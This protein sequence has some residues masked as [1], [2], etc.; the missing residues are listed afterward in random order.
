MKT[1]SYLKTVCVALLAPIIAL[2]AQDVEDDEESIFTLS[3]F[4][5]QEDEAIGY[6]ALSTLA[7]TRIKTD[8][9]DVG[10]AI[11]VYTEE[12]MED[13]GATDGETLLSYGLNTETI[14]EQG[15]FAGFGGDTRVLLKQPQIAGQRVRGITLPGTQGS[16][17]LTRDFFLTDMPFDSYNTTAVTVNRGPNSLLFGTGKAG[18]IINNATIQASVAESFGEIQI[19]I[20]ENSSHREQIDYNKVLVQDRLAIRVAAL[21]EDQQFHQRPSFQTDER[22]F[23]TLT[24]VLSKNESSDFFGPTILR[25]NIETADLDGTPVKVLPPPDDISDWWN[26]S[27]HAPRVAY[28]EETW[29]GNVPDFVDGSSD[30]QGTFIPQYTTGS[31]HRMPLR[32]DGAFGDEPPGAMIGAYSGGSVLYYADINDPNPTAG[33]SMPGLHGFSG[34][35]FWDQSE[36]CAD[37]GR[38]WDLQSHSIFTDGNQGIGRRG[39]WTRPTLNNR[40]VLDNTKIN[41]GGNLNRSISEFDA[42]NITLEQQLFDGKGGIEFAYD[43]QSY[44]SHS[45]TPYGDWF[46]IGVDVNENL[47]NDQ[48]NP[49][50]G[51]AFKVAEIEQRKNRWDRE[52]NR[53]TAFYEIDLTEQEGILGWLGRHVL[54]G[55]WNEQQIDFLDLDARNRWDEASSNNDYAGRSFRDI[56]GGGLRA[57]SGR[58]GVFMKIYLSD[59][60][61]GVSRFEDVRLNEYPRARIPGEGT[62]WL[63][64]WQDRRGADPNFPDVQQGPLPNPATIADPANYQ[65][66]QGLGDPLY[67]NNFK[68]TDITVQVGAVNRQVIESE[69]LAWQGKWWNDHIVTLLGWRTDTSVSQS[70]LGGGVDAEGF[71]LPEQYQLGPKNPKLEGNTTTVGV[72]AHLPDEWTGDQFGMSFHYNESDSFEPK[73]TSFNARV[74]AL[75]SP[76]AVTEDYGLTFEFLN[77]ALSLRLSKYEMTVFATAGIGSSEIERLTGVLSGGLGVQEWADAWIDGLDFDETYAQSARFGNVGNFS[78]YQDVLNALDSFIPEP[79]RSTVNPHFGPGQ[80][81]SPDAFLLVDRIPNFAT[82]SDVVS[83]GTE[84]E[85][86]GNITSNW[87]V[88]LN[89]GEQ[90]TSQSNSQ[91]AL[92]AVALE[93]QQNLR[94]LNLH[95]LQ[96]NPL[97]DVDETIGDVFEGIV[98]TPILNARARDGTVSQEQR[99]KRINLITAYDWTEGPLAGFGAGGAYRWQDEIAAGYPKIVS[100]ETGAIIDDVTQP[101]FGPS[102]YN[103]DL[104]FS[105][106]GKFPF[107]LPFFDHEKMDWK[108]QLNT[109]NAFGDDDYIPVRYNPDGYI[110]VVRNP[111]PRSFWLTNTFSF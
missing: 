90:E 20:G 66:G 30:A 69:A 78:S 40:Q 81:P 80:P 28:M 46:G 67:Y 4:T 47:P 6:Q 34:I 72:V 108:I 44:F 21:N 36:C 101:I 48:P 76:N 37:R 11:S 5:I 17:S 29:T 54:T 18:G 110:A 106:A 51:R 10:A 22:W 74:E 102:T 1:T 43:E 31:F 24:A 16:A 65:G 61:R 58:F 96:E 83:E 32:A 55:L 41:L 99:R 27:R 42:N 62:D 71:P 2:Y 87:R 70:Q 39:G 105:Y 107:G 23:A 15:N 50:V 75:P 91:P 82:Q 85:L 63:I 64:G 93:A 57:R 8:L 19:R 7:G 73:S 103:V 95:T 53:V 13:T 3:P 12:F 59:D 109:R 92:L 86:I 52:A 68:N 56:Y 60:L 88:A 33:T 100:P 89:Y 25:A 98:L 97:D 94:N 104:W 84:I 49:N 26:V 45:L 111:N 35:I 14:G 9:R 77:R 79:T 38:Y